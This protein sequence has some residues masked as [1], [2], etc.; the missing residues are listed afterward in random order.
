ML[1]GAA[2]LW[3]AGLRFV[4]DE[5]LPSY[6]PNTYVELTVAVGVLL[7]IGF[8][9]SGHAGGDDRE[10]LLVLDEKGLRI[11][12]YSESRIFW[13]ELKEVKLKADTGVTYLLIYLNEPERYLNGMSFWAKRESGTMTAFTLAHVAVNITQSEEDFETIF[14]TIEEYRAAYFEA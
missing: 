9:V 10:L 14:K 7:F 2:I 3:I 12:G 1:V 8:L 11:P 6:L 13:L 5:T 4:G